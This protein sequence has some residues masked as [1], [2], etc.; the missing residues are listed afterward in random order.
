MFA[1]FFNFQIFVF[2][3][4]KICETYFPGNFAL[5]NFANCAKTPPYFDAIMKNSK[6]LEVIKEGKRWGGLVGDASMLEEFHKL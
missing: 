5:K 2:F 1:Q 6:L 4:S 3:I